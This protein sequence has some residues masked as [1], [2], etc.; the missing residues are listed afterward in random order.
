MGTW[1]DK[2][3]QFRYWLRSLL[4]CLLSHLHAHSHISTET[5]QVGNLD[6]RLPAFQNTLSLTTDPSN[7][8]SVFVFGRLERNGPLSV[9]HIDVDKGK[10]EMLD[11]KGERKTLGREGDTKKDDRLFRSLSVG[12]I[13]NVPEL[14]ASPL[15]PLSLFN[16]D[17]FTSFY[18]F[19]TSMNK[20]SFLICNVG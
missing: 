16:T 18:T 6:A 3:C 9:F 11:V 20:L 2:N 8:S 13:P 5:G 1:S 15:S 17:T 12:S 4:A 10:A 19:D 7:S 14:L